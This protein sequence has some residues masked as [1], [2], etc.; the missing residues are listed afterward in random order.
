[1][2]LYLG[3][4]N[5]ACQDVILLAGNSQKGNNET[6][7]GYLSVQIYNTLHSAFLQ[8]RFT[9]FLWGFASACSSWPLWVFMHFGDL[10][11]LIIHL[12]WL[13]GNCKYCNFLACFAKEQVLCNYTVHLSLLFITHNFGTCWLNSAKLECPRDN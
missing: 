1:M 13:P 2:T 3:S 5:S 9:N 7:E 4:W 10:S 6:Q 12:F 8:I 11:K